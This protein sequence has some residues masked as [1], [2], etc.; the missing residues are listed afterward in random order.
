MSLLDTWDYHSPDGAAAHRDFVV[1]LGRG[2]DSGGQ[3]IPICIS[4]VVH[5]CRSSCLT[6]DHAQELRM[7]MTNKWPCGHGRAGA[8][9]RVENQRKTDCW[10]TQEQMR[11]TFP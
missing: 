4:K 8:V 5:V 9:A 6:R 10:S 1:V 11:Y 2:R 7:V 3:K